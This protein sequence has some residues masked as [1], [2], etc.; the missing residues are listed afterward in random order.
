MPLTAPCVRSCLCNEWVVGAR[1]T[2]C[3][4]QLPDRLG[5]VRAPTARIPTQRSQWR[6]ASRLGASWVVVDHFK[7]FLQQLLGGSVA[8]LSGELEDLCGL[9]VLLTFQENRAK[10]IT[11]SRL[12]VVLGSP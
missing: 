10:G 8:P 4:P 1:R 7:F 3:D 6:V 5:L 11:P 2:S 12:V 9:L